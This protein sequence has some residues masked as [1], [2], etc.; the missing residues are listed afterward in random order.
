MYYSSSDQYSRKMF[1]VLDELA[2][3]LQ[4]N[5]NIVIG[6]FDATENEVAGLVVS[7]YP[8]FKLI[9][10]VDGKMKLVDFYGTRTVEGIL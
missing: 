8:S 7:T 6:R 4:V 10:K 3:K 2:K 1:P 5:P 9:K